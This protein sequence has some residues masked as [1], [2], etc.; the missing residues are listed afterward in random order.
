MAKGNAENSDT[1]SIKASKLS[2]QCQSSRAGSRGMST[3]EW[4]GR[5]SR[6]SYAGYTLLLSDD[7]AALALFSP[8]RI[9]LVTVGN[10]AGP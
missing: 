6:L 9:I 4:T 8:L 7:A 5:N 10:I 2:G 3:D 1:I